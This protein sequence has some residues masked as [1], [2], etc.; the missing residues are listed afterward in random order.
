MNRRSAAAVVVVLLGSLGI[1][2]CSSSTESSA[3]SPAPTESVIGGTATCDEASL[4]AAVEAA[5]TESDP[6]MSIFFVDGFECA[7]GWAVIFPT[8]GT[9][10][11]NSVTVTEVLQ[12]EGQFWLVKDRAEVC[13]TPVDGDPTAV[14]ADSQVPAEIYQPACNTN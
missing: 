7:D 10:E 6:S 9:T 11:E 2:G 5:M 1:A 3:S 13:G 12:A 14:P 8:I 4:R